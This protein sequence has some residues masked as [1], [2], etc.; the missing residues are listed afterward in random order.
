[1]LTNKTTR[2]P[3]RKNRKQT[4]ACEIEID[5]VLAVNAFP[6]IHFVL[7]RLADCRRQVS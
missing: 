7:P 3:N 4:V 2:L 1:M 5:R 6:V